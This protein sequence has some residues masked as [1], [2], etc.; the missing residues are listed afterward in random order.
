MRKLERC[1]F[2]SACE[3]VWR[4][5]PVARESANVGALIIRIGF[6]GGYTKVIIRNPQNSIGNS[7]GPYIGM[8]NESSGTDI[9]GR[10][11]GLE[12]WG[13]GVRGLEV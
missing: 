11:W 9:K 8:M 10:I 12:A 3:S 5:R 4:L 13:S 2:L 7:L 1:T 6:W